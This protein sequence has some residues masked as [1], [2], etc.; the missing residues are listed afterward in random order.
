MTY[1]NPY[2]AMPTLSHFPNATHTMYKLTDLCGIFK[3]NEGYCGNV[4]LSEQR[5]ALMSLKFDCPDGAGWCLIVVAWQRHKNR[6]WF[7]SRFVNVGWLR[8]A[9]ITIV[10]TVIYWH[11]MTIFEQPLRE[12]AISDFLDSDCN[13]HTWIFNWRKAAIRNEILA[14]NIPK[15]ILC[16]GL[17]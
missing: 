1:V 13:F 14:N 2:W 12:D 4:T 7:Q 8:C 10:N 6:K 9:I 15:L 17:K 3:I 16:K 5:A 11:P